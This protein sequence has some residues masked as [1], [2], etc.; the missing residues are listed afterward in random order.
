MLGSLLPDGAPN[1]LIALSTVIADHAGGR[2]RFAAFFDAG[3]AGQL[4]S[5]FGEESRQ[6]A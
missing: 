2:F 5:E 4:I 6:A 3:Q 1:W